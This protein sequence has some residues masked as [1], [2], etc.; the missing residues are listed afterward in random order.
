MNKHERGNM[1]FKPSKPW[2]PRLGLGILFAT[3]TVSGQYTPAQLSAVES[4][5][6]SMKSDVPLTL[7]PLDSVQ[8]V[9]LQAQLPDIQL[10]TDL[11]KTTSQL[12]AGDPKSVPPSLKQQAMAG[13]VQDVIDFTSLG[14]DTSN[15]SLN[16][17]GLVSVYGGN[18]Y[19][20]AGISFIDLNTYQRIDTATMD[21]SLSGV[22]MVFNAIAAASP[23]QKPAA[24]LTMIVSPQT[25]A[26]GA[27]C[28]PRTSNITY[29]QSVFLAVPPP[30]VPVVS[31]PT[32]NVTQAGKYI[33][34]CLGRQQN[35]GQPTNCDYWDST[36]SATA[37]PMM[38]F[39]FQGFVKLS[40]PI[41][42]VAAPQMYLQV[43]PTGGGCSQLNSTMGTAGLSA[44]PGATMA[45]WT[46][47]NPI[48]PYDGS[49][50]AQFGLLNPPT[51]GQGSCYT[52]GL[53]KIFGQLNITDNTGQTVIA[54]FSS[55][56]ADKSAYTGTTVDSTFLAWGCVLKG[57]AVALPG[58]KTKPIERVVVGD[59]VISNAKGN[60]LV[61]THTFIGREHK[62]MFR[63]ADEFGDEAVLTGDHPVMTGSGFRIARDIRS[64]DVVQ[65]VSPRAKNGKA[66][67]IRID[68]LFAEAGKGKVVHNLRLDAKGA[69]AT[70]AAGG[71]V[72]GDQE[73]QNQTN[74]RRVA[75]AMKRTPPA[76]AGW[77][78][79]ASTL[80]RVASNY[81]S[82]Y[83]KALRK[84]QSRAKR[85]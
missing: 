63:L 73:N 76:T 85:K 59:T 56:P 27:D 33:M 31:I 64:G 46:L 11:P 1:K 58:G 65:S 42:S 47:M 48:N 37:N 78:K 60:K 29:A 53:T 26:P 83:S 25:C 19:T 36:Q 43:L 28:A 32:H 44:P 14:E 6:R 4:V 30:S 71:I 18:T 17:T 9:F 62:A 52:Q 3:A 24:I 35:G 38:R 81:P 50:W 45:T 8:A 34:I 66:K 41:A 21:A 80:Q 68:T 61:V 7:N 20:L 40:H 16:A 84:V 49:Q 82:R 67:I 12:R 22:D 10:L 75:M 54:K 2:F 51:P 15:Q 23:G 70:F 5:V 77:E 57:T 74:N 69:S 55:S 13:Q 39:P 79:D 72:V